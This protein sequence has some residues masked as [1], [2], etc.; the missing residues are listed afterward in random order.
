M[1]QDFSNTRGKRDMYT[2]FFKRCEMLFCLVLGLILFIVIPMLI[3]A[4]IIRCEDPGPVIFKQKR[5]GLHKKHFYFIKFRSM[6]M[7]TPHDMPTHMLSNPEQYI[8]KVGGFIQDQ[9]R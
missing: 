8:L 1:S 5:I 6:K 7:D 4:I 3:V 2:K 9:H